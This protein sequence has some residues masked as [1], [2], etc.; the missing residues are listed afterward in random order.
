MLRIVVVVVVG[1]EVWGVTALV[2][3]EASA[4]FIGLPRFRESNVRG[5][6]A[7]SSEDPARDGEQRVAQEALGLR[8]VL[9]KVHPGWRKDLRA[10]NTLHANPDYTCVQLINFSRRAIAGIGVEA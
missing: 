4:S 1:G 5:L 8:A 2:A 3:P 7:V 6:C 9:R 10:Q